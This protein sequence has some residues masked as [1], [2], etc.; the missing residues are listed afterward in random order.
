MN[1]RG[2]ALPT[3]LLALLF[4]TAVAS[5]VLNAATRRLE[6]GTRLLAARKALAAADGAVAWHGAAWDTTLAGSLVPGTVAALP[7]PTLPGEVETR[8]SLVRL[9]P[10]LYLLRSTG[11]VRFGAR[12]V[13]RQ[14][15]AQLRRSSSRGSQFVP[16]GWWQWE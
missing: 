13:A 2:I 9:G 11:I 12:E 3:A 7:A 16:G 4:S 10:G 8:D 15:V 1:R 5:L 14:A 6:A